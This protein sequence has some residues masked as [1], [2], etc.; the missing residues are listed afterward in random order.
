MLTP[1]GFPVVAANCPLT[2][3][4]DDVVA[5]ERVLGMREGPLLLV[6]H[7]WCGMITEA[8][9]DPKSSG[10]V[11]IAA[12]AP[13]SGLSFNE[14]WAS[15]PPAP[16]APEIIPYGPGK[17]VA[18]T[19]N[20]FRDHLGQ[21]LPADEITLLHVTQGPF[22]QGSNDEKIT[23]A[24]WRSQPTWFVIGQN[25]HMLMFDLE[26]ATAETLKAKTLVLSAGHLTML[27]QPYEVA[28]FIEDTAD[29]L[30]SSK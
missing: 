25:D 2:S 24:A 14:W 23:T 15:S 20:G 27:P 19:R 17:F 8:G 7:S 30:G 9:N 1:K 18:L 22:N 13:G 21:D 26:K 12:A 4:V 11:Y 5:V 3:Q 10:L 16:G 29:E 28:D 6:G